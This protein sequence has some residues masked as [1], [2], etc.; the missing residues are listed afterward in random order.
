MKLKF[1]SQGGERTSPDWWG[2]DLGVYKPII[3]LGPSHFQEI[4][5][6]EGD[7]TLHIGSL[8]AFSFAS[9]GIYF[10]ESAKSLPL[11]SLLSS[12]QNF[13]DISS[14]TLPIFVGLHCF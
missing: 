4:K 10:P 5:A 9:F 11:Y 7:S 12:S 8:L 3:I 1:F 2:D 13:I 6:F 14:S